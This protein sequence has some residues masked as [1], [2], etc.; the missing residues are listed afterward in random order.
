VD[1]FENYRGDLGLFAMRKN[2]EID[3]ADRTRRLAEADR[4]RYRQITPNYLPI[5]RPDCRRLL[6]APN[7]FYDS[8]FEISKTPA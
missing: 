4:L 3:R 2:T 6:E 5:K 1:S 8:V 7:T